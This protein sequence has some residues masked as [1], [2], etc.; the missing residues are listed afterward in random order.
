MS[1]VTTFT[2]SETIAVAPA[3][4]YEAFT[5]SDML[6]QWLCNFAVVR[7]R[8]G[9]YIFLQWPE[10][11]F[12]AGEYQTLRPNETIVFSWQGRGETAV[13]TVRVALAE[14]DGRTRLTLHHEAI[15]T[16]EEWAQ[17]RQELQQGWETG[18]SNLKSVL[19]TGLDRRIYDQPFLGIL[20]SGTVSTEQAES[21]GLPVSGGLRISG[22][23]PETGAAA[24][25]LQDGDIIVNLGG[26]EVTD[27]PSLRAALRPFKAGETVKLTYYRHGEKHSDML[28]LSQRPLPRV[29]ETPAA[30]A[31]E[32]RDT[33]GQ[34]DGELEDLLHGVTETEASHRPGEGEWHVKDVLAHLI[35]TERQLQIGL[36]N[37]ISGNVSDTFPDNPDAWNR[38]ITA[39]YPTL[40]DLVALWQRTE[41]ETVALA[42]ALPPDF[43]ANKIR[44]AN[45]ANSLLSGYPS[46]TRGHFDQM[47]AAIAAARAA[48]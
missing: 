11:Y 12:A 4:V 14:E 28:L 20:I 5:N 19:E 39:V 29:P 43:V 48:V 10:G 40:P 47:R 9:G 16:A 35:G 45:A 24:L 21:L 33:Y 25:N 1:E 34:L 23:A 3:L 8:E 2:F 22:T 32:L 30:L 31:E 44:Y 41:A 18:L 7:P 46:H 27:L 42:A 26:G 36:A 13:S 6:R 38:S 17:T 15:P 37:Q